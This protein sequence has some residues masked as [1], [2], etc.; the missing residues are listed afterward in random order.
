MIEGLARKFG[1][2]QKKVERQTGWQDM[3]IHRMGI[4]L[5]Q[6]ARMAGMN[7]LAKLKTGK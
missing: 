6:Y 2:S 3:I 5:L 7:G 1:E 4:I